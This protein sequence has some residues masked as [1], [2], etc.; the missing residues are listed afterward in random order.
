VSKL[1]KSAKG[2]DCEIRIPGT[3][4]GNPETVVLCH[5]H[6]GGMAG[7]RSDIHGA[8]GCSSC[9]AVVDGGVPVRW[10]K[11]MLDLWFLQ[12]VIRTQEKML[13]EGLIR[14]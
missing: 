10:P 12:A 13:A 6:G 7:K 1:R 5:F 3:C 4:N 8:Y 9:H 2:R 11:D 14:V